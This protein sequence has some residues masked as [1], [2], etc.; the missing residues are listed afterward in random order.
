MGN[1]YIVWSMDM[2]NSTRHCRLW[3]NGKRYLYT[4]DPFAEEECIEA[5]ADNIKVIGDPEWLRFIRSFIS[6]WSERGEPEDSEPFSGSYENDNKRLILNPYHTYLV[7]GYAY[8]YCEEYWVKKPNSALSE[9]KLVFAVYLDNA[10]GKSHI[11][12]FDEDYLDT[13]RE[14]Y[15]RVQDAYEIE[16]LSVPTLHT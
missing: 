16:S 5:H 6:V 12:C 14:A 8:N 11:T 15:A 4:E 10:M 1:R 3:K 9:W 13:T 7:D 2:D